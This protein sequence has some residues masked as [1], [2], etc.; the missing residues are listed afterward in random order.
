[1][2][3]MRRVILEGPSNMFRGIHSGPHMRDWHPPPKSGY[4]VSTFIIEQPVLC[5][6]LPYRVAPVF[7]Q[8]VSRP[9]GWYAL[10]SFPVVCSPRGATRSPERVNHST[11]ETGSTTSTFSPK[12]PLLNQSFLFSHNNLRPFKKN[13][14]KC[15]KPFTTHV[16]DGNICWL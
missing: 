10:S 12:T 1:M 6:P 3:S 7:V 9:L 5:C 13:P 15:I 14:Q 16:T 2:S 4:I 11:L 8:V